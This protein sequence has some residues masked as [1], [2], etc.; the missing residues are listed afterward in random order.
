VIDRSRLLRAADLTD[1]AR[2]QTPPKLKLF[3]GNHFLGVRHHR[4]RRETSCMCASPGWDCQG[5]GANLYSAVWTNV[6]CSSVRWTWV[7]FQ[8]ASRIARPSAEPS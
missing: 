6:T 7:A 1:A 8:P 5:A 2:D 4:G 3:V